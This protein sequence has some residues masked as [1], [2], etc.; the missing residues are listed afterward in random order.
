MDRLNK[1]TQSDISLQY[2][3]KGDPTIPVGV[4]GMVDDTLAVAECG[5]NSIKK[6]SVINSFIETHRLKLSAEKSVV[7]H[8]TNAKKCPVLCPVLKVHKE[9]MKQV[10]S[11]KY[12]ENIL[13]TSGGINN[14][15]E[16]RRSQGWGKIATI[17][18]ILSE[19]DMGVHKVEVGL[20]LRQAILIN[21][22]LFSAEAWSSVTEKQL[23]RL[24]VVDTAL[25][26]RLTGGHSKCGTEFHHLETATWKLRHHLSY[27]RIMFHH[28]ILTRD[29]NETIHKIYNKQKEETL[30]G[31]WLNSINSD[32]DFLKMKID[33]NRQ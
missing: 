17:M 9:D 8:Y 11:T 22:M 6:N 25:L 1:I 14:M 27:R 21:S 16:D 30:K 7:L 31:D 2:L 3:Y 13:S 33:E 5:Q 18:G 19:V 29:K 24:E 26:R 20:M 10:N 23:A 28:H 4:L 12:L 15:V 32:F